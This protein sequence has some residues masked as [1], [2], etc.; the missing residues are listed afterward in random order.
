MRGTGA[1]RGRGKRT[2]CFKVSEELNDALERLATLS[3]VSKSEL[4]RLAIALMMQSYSRNPVV[5]MVVR[6]VVV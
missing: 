2:I 5:R 4:I 3:M 6:K 1:V